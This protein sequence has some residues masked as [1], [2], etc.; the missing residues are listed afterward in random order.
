MIH[1]FDFVD[2]KKIRIR[3]GIEFEFCSGTLTC[4]VPMN[5]DTSITATFTNQAA[6]QAQL[7]NISTR[8]LVEAGDNVQIG[9]FIIGGTD[10]KTVLI[11]ARGPVLADFWGA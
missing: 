4:A 8:G 11:R 10:P 7:T 6:S 1:R 3:A 2:R 5:A 9:G